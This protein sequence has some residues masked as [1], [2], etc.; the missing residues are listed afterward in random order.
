MKRVLILASVTAL[1]TS[2]GHTQSGPARVALGDFFKP[3]VVFQDKNGDSVVDFVNARV[4]LAPQPTAGELAAAADIAAR[5]RFDTSALALPLTAPTPDAESP[6]VF[7]GAKSLAGA[8]VTVDA[9]LAGTPLKAG[10]G[11]V[12]AF[13]AGNRPALAVLGGDDNGLAAAGIQLA[14]RLPYVW[15]PKGPTTEKIADDVKEF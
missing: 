6:A 15:D 3:G 12:T 5:L 4:A 11:F 2:I 13:S 8:G 7:V 10:D 9:L 1:T 14:G